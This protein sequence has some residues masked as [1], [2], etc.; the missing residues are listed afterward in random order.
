VPERLDP[1]HIKKGFGVSRGARSAHA[2]R[3]VDRI[4]L[5]VTDRVVDFIRKHADRPF[6]ANLNLVAPHVPIAPAKEF[7]GK[8]GAGDY[9][10]F[11]LQMDACVGRVLDALDQFGLTDNTLVVLTSD[12]GAVIHRET[13]A[14][15]HRSN[16]DL[17]GQKTDVWE[18]GVR[19]PFIARWPGRIPS[20]E[21]T[22]A[23]I[24]L[25]DL[26]RT[27]WTAA[28]ADLPLPVAPESLNQLTVLLHPASLG[29]RKEMMYL[30]TH[31]AYFAIRSGD[32]VYLPG[33]GSFGHTTDPSSPWLDLAKQGGRNSDYDAQ[34]RLR[35]NAPKEQLYDL[36][37]D[38]QQTTNIIREHPDVAVAMAKRLRQFMSELQEESQA[39]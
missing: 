39:R 15:G 36:R 31:P 11:V 21:T 34:G 20:G 19:V 3:P 29:E 8:T 17:L 16:F 32:W 23:L 25:S 26:G 5:I 35:P 7:R 18:G 14:I 6:F 12:N 30:G 1:D 13:L 10:D 38:P 22:R 9:G 27:F 37:A 24:A 33:Q 2:A 28:G 4:D